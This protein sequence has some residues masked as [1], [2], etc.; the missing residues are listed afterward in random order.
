M[1]GYWFNQ[2]YGYLTAAT[3]VKFN[4]KYIGIPFKQKFPGV[5]KKYNVFGKFKTNKQQVVNLVNQLY[6]VSG[7]FKYIIPPKYPL[8]NKQYNV[9]GKFKYE[10]DEQT[11]YLV[12]KQY[13]VSGKFKYIESE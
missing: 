10:K 3:T 9:S 6:N 12:N 11:M 7:I 2:N 13:N 1:R 8:V 5:S 4:R